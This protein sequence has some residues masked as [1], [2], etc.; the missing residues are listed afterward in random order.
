MNHSEFIPLRSLG[1]GSG[2]I[3]VFLILR[4]KQLG[5]SGIVMGVARFITCAAEV[6]MFQIAGEQWL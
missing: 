5:A 3:D 2:V 4:L 1:I 6:P